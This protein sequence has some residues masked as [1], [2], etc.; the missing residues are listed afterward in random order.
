[1]TGTGASVF[2][3]FTSEAQAKDVLGNIPD[4][5]NGFIS[6]GVNIS[7]LLDRQTNQVC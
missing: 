2:G 7:P 3:I 4:A 6:Q 1:M 5:W